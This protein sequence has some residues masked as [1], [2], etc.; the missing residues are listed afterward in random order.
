M[1]SYHPETQKEY[2]NMTT[3]LFKNSLVNI[4]LFAA[5]AFAA[6]FGGQALDAHF[7][8]GKTIMII[9]LFVAFGSSWFIVLKRNAK[10][11]REYK[12]IREKMKQEQ[13]LS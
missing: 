12:A 7:G 9:L 3:K 4:P 1:Q 11:S 6:L 10:L 8:T 5:P 13:T 2:D